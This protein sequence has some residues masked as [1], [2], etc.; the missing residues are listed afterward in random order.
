MNTYL[1]NSRKLRKC[2]KNL[3]NFLNIHFTEKS[4]WEIMPLNGLNKNP[5]I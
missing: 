5:T 3:E 2:R 4:L 1:E